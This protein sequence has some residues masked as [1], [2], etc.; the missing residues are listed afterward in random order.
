MNF[1]LRVTLIG[2]PNSGGGR[3]VSSALASDDPQQPI[4]VVS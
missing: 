4:V 3:S 1:F 2:L